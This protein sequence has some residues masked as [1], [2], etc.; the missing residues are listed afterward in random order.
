M[1]ARPPNVFGTVAIPFGHVD[2]RWQAVRAAGAPAAVNVPAGADLA[3]TAHA[4]DQWVNGAVTYQREMVDAWA[5]PAA[6]LAA[7]HGDCEDFAILKRAILR[8]HGVPDERLYLT[9]LWDAISRNQHAILLVDIDFEFLVLDCFNA[10]TLPSAQVMD[11]LPITTMA[12]D[13]CWIHGRR[14]GTMHT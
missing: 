8:A 5:K 14:T 6:T 3:K 11:Y 10:L 9:L 4:V 12:A 7:R 1:T 13:Q 2:A